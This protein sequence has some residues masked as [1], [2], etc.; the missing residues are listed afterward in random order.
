MYNMKQKTVGLRELRHKARHYIEQVRRGQSLTITDRG[1]AV[2]EIVPHRE[3]RGV[4]EHWRMDGTVEPAVGKLAEIGLPP[5][6]LKPKVNAQE[7]LEE[8][9]QE[10]M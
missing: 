3:D 10:R 6:G 5:D 2:A 8:L 4:L 7:A 9:R 1:K